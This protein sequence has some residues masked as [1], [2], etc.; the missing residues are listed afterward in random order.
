MIPIRVRSGR[1]Q[2]LLRQRDDP[3]PSRYDR[4]F[5]AWRLLGGH[6]PGECGEADA[7]KSR[8]VVL[9]R[10][11]E[12]RR[13]VSRPAGDARR[14]IATEMKSVLKVHRQPNTRMA[15]EYVAP[16][17]FAPPHRQR[18]GLIQKVALT[19][20]DPIRRV[21][22]HSGTCCRRQRCCRSLPECQY[23]HHRWYCG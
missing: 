6:D 22:R 23:R 5:E 18:R 4:Y 15:A 11:R 10:H 16:P 2:I 7:A 12:G 13:R 14:S 9:R 21:F 8:A 1:V 20:A 3:R 17:P 19:L